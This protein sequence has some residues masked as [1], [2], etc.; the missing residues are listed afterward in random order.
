MYPT[1]LD[2]VS[3][4]NVIITL[5]H[6]VKAGSVL[7]KCIVAQNA[8]CYKRQWFASGGGSRLSALRCFIFKFGAVIAITGFA[9]VLEWIW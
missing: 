6:I 1:I 4:D 3:V 8:E 2:V 7:S 5:T 9:K